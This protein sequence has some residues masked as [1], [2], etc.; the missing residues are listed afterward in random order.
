[1]I[2]TDDCKGQPYL[3]CGR[4]SYNMELYAL[5]CPECGA[6]LRVDAETGKSQNFCEYC[7]RRIVQ[8]DGVRR[9]EHTENINITRRTVDEAELRRAEARL[10]ETSI[11]EQQELE[12]IRRRSAKRKRK[13]FIW[14]VLIG[15]IAFAYV[16][17]KID[18]AVRAN[19]KSKIVGQVKEVC[20]DHAST[21]DDIRIRNKTIDIDILSGSSKRS[22]VDALQE[23]LLGAITVKDGYEVDLSFYKPKHNRVRWVSVNEFGSVDV[24]IDDT[25]ELSDEEAEDLVKSYKDSL[26]ELPGG[27]DTSL[28]N[29][30]YKGDELQIRIR[31]KTCERTQVQAIV[32]SISNANRRLEN[33]AMEI[34]LED[35]SG[36]VLYRTK[37]SAE[38]KQEVKDDYTNEMSDEEMTRIIK[39]YGDSLKKAASSAGGQMTKV[40]VKNDILKVS[41]TVEFND[42][43]SVK[44]LEEK[45]V[46]AVEKFKERDFD[47]DFTAGKDFST[48]KEWKI[49]SDGT[50]EVL[51]DLTKDE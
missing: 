47:I 3:S 30:T 32:E 6:P 5:K 39:E 9:T 20:Q 37:I 41:L 33:K 7:G 51:R 1:M 12:K 28:K 40:R 36:Y 15:L 10:K 2:R 46:S 8:D 44:K 25:G 14:L 11:I 19:Y 17:S 45:L 13:A 29:V 31:C 16:R 43:Q 21:V 23:D 18:D 35:D 27:E 49:S 42:K 26:T 50:I 48:V 22:D 24:H 4:E 38:G 34:V